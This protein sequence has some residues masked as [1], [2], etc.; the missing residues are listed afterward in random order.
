MHLCGECGGRLIQAKSQA[1]RVWY[2]CEHHKLCGNRL[3]ACTACGIGL[4]RRE[5][6]PDTKSCSHCGETTT[7]CPACDDGWLVE[8]KG[9]YGAFLG[10]VRYPDC[11]GKEKKPKVRKK[12]SRSRN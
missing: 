3:P 10:C 9:R 12:R 4:P 11:S 6:S 2:M 7:A 5:T 8:R 1:D